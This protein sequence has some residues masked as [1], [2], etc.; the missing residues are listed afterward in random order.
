M[1]RLQ[2]SPYKAPTPTIGHL[3]MHQTGGNDREVQ[4]FRRESSYLSRVPDACSLGEI[5]V[6]IYVLAE[7][8]LCCAYNILNP[9]TNVLRSLVYILASSIITL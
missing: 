5:H 6:V 1:I 3:V 2:C 8:I 4:I 9:G 7:R